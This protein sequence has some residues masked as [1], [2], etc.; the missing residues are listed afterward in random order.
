MDKNSS[1]H[2]GN[3]MLLRMHRQM[4]MGTACS[5]QCPLL[6][7]RHQSFAAGSAS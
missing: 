1:N 7:V 4:M 3:C 2:D 6:I 5:S